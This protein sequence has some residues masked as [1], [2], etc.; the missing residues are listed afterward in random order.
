MI[1]QYFVFKNENDNNNKKYNFLFYFSQ[2]NFRGPNI[3]WAALQV[4]YI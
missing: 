2:D 1:L 4:N 3:Y